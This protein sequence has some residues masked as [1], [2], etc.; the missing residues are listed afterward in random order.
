MAA[1]LERVP[2]RPARTFREG[3]Q[4]IWLT[5]VALHQENGNMALSFGR[6]DQILGALLEAELADNVLTI[7]QAAELLGC[8]FLK[9]GDHMPL[10]PAAGRRLLGGASTD[11]AITIGG[12][13]PR[14]EEGVN[15]LTYLMLRVAGM[16]ALR[17]PNLCARFHAKSP[18]G[19]RRAV[20]ETL[21]QTGAA[22]ALFGD[23]PTFEALMAK[24]VRLQHARDYGIIGCVEPSSAGRTMGATGAILLNLAAVLELTLHDGIHPLS[25]TRVGPSTGKLRELTTFEAFQRAF[26]EQLTR[27]VSLC[28]DGNHRL[29]KAHAELHPTPLLSSLIEGTLDSGRDVTCGGATYDSTGV[30]VIGLADVAD[31]FAA[32]DDAVYGRGRISLTALEEAIGADFV[33]HE[34]EHAWLSRRCP[35][36]GR[37]DPVADRHA[38]E[39]LRAVDAAFAAHKNPRGGPFHVGL[40]SLTMHAGYG[41]LTGALPSGRRKGAPLASGA[42]PVSGAAIKGPTAAMASTQRLS[43][44]HL[45]N[46][47]ANNHKLPR[48]LLGREDKL[49]AFERLV[50]GYFRG[51]G[52]QVQFTVQDRETLLAAQ[53]EPDAYR[54]LLVRVSGYTAYF[55]DLDRAMQDEII[56]RTEDIL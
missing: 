13:T 32:L 30:A 23:E 55:C 38:V 37:D 16:L 17:E 47:M 41:A 1:I 19:Y 18:S 52:M 49:D 14:G 48:S 28:V 21:R 51:G 7:P 27:M 10:V 53:A 54:D 50:G 29:A 25:G 20:V 43:P 26:S 2:A 34:R 22:P 5:Q 39:L 3:L 15:A 36:Y 11:Q 42:T 12:L 6:L 45:G 4:S 9:L 40:W 56:S 44:C 35:K 46:G 31:S 33:G 24:G 8:F